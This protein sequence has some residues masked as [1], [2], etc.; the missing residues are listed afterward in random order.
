MF[1]IIESIDPCY[2]FYIHL[3]I[4]CHSLQFMLEWIQNINLDLD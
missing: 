1:A 4:G 2:S 3:V